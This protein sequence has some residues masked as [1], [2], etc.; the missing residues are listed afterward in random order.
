[1]ILDEV[2]LAT[3]DVFR[4][5]TTEFRT[6]MKL[7]LTATMVREDNLIEDLPFLVGP[8]FHEVDLNVLRMNDHVAEVKCYHIVCPLA[9]GYVEA[10][11]TSKNAEQRRLLYIT[12]PNKFRVCV[13]LLR[14]HVDRGHKCLVFCDDLFGLEVCSKLLKREYV[15]GHTPADMREKRLKSFREAAGGAYILISKVGDHS[16]DLPEANV[17]I[18]FGIVDGSRMQ[19]AQRVGRIQRRGKKASPISYFYAIISDNTPEVG[20]IARRT[21]FMEEHGYVYQPGLPWEEYLQENTTY[22]TIEGTIS[23]LLEQI[24]K[25]LH[26]KAKEREQSNMPKE[27]RKPAVKKK[28]TSRSRLGQK[29]RSAKKGSQ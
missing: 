29:L 24:D 19:E 10:Y 17:V 7:G 14:Y 18:Q 13:S 28:G 22:F 25:E 2:H 26:T 23:Q 9:D 27:A 15:A 12:N 3:A 8:K 1:M 11:R 16:I 5:V 6:H 21:T 20:F 4:D